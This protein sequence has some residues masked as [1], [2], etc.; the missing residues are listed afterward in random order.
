MCG[1]TSGRARIGVLWFS[2]QGQI[3]RPEPSDWPP[4]EFRRRNATW[5]LPRYPSS[6]GLEHCR[7]CPE[8][9]I[10]LRARNDQRRRQRDS[11]A[12]CPDQHAVFKSFEK[13]GE[14]A[15]RWGVRHGF[16][17][18]CANQADIAHVDDMRETAQRVDGKARARR[19]AS[20]IPRQRRC[21]GFQGRPHRRQ[22]DRST[23]IRARTR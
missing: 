21:R 1:G 13:R 19:R 8:Q 20:A 16:E 10:D 14:S 4:G 2:L 12:G 11:V 9:L 7:Q 23:C 6:E 5:A 18:N 3:G 15:L 22:G 17:L